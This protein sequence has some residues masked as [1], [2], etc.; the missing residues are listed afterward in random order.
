MNVLSSSKE[1]R[2]KIKVIIIRKNRIVSRL[3]EQ[4]AT[5]LRESPP[6]FDGKKY[7]VTPLLIHT[8]MELMGLLVATDIEIIIENLLVKVKITS[9]NDDAV[10]GTGD[11]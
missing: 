2:E 6:V 11:I 7:V 10:G 8:M 4:V 1:K 5:A 9:A 3:A